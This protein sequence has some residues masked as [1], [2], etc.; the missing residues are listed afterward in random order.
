[1]IINCTRG[2]EGQQISFEQ[3]K[4]FSA[5]SPLTKGESTNRARPDIQDSFSH[6][7]SRSIRMWFY[8]IASGQ[9]ADPN[10]RRTKVLFC[11]VYSV[12]CLSE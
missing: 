6:R 1:M 3:A 4:S 7:F 10:F 8:S 5:H 12:A 9:F 11:L 2:T